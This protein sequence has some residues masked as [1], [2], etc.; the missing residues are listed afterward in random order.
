[1]A[2]DQAK[3]PTAIRRRAAQHLESI[4][5]TPMA[6]SA[7]G[8]TLGP[9]VWPIYRPD[10]EEIA[11]YEFTIE[12]ASGAGR[13]ATSA[14]GL[15]ALLEAERSSARVKPKRASAG[16][17]ARRPQS[18]GG[19]GFVVAASGPHDFPIPHWSL[20]RP[21]IS[22]QLATDAE[23][24]ARGIERITKLDSLAYVA[25]SKDG[26]LLAQVGQLPALLAGLPH[27]LSRA[28]GGISTL[29]AEPAGSVPNDDRA[30][31]VEHR[32]KR[33]GGEPPDLKPVEVEGWQGLRER[34]ADSFGP[35]LD[36]LRR[37]AAPAWE[38]EA[39]IEE[40]G[41]G[42]HVGQTHRVALLHPDAVVDVGGAGSSLVK[43]YIDERG[44][45][46]ALVIEV[47]E[48]TEIDQE[49]DLEVDIRYADGVAERLRF[50]VVSAR[51]PSNR[52]TMPSEGGM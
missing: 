34:Y 42:I 35:Y 9:E 30:E 2:L 23:Q 44:A 8:A 19:L 4:R 22:A 13:L 41:E 18:N 14:A 31:G 32:V 26:S 11:Y 40:F 24:G 48:G 16:A 29:V 37:R 6:P 21:P 5:G 36:E 12:L 10:L 33:E 47:P 43:A 1:M 27:D 39:L 49:A 38:I 52:R 17:T 28:D 45:S 46:A 20:E 25:E 50:F 7:E 51:T 3:V 15:S